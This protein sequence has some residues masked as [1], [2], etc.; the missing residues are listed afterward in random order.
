MLHKST[1]F[2]MKATPAWMEKLRDIVKIA[3][4]LGFERATATSVVTNL[5][6]WHFA[7]CQ[8]SERKA[9]GT[10]GAFLS[11]EEW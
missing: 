7:A 2:N 11:R 9:A 10:I 4:E 5:V 6:N 8:F 1:Q 3:R